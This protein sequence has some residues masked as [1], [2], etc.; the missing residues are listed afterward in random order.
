MRC[1]RPAL[2]LV[3]LSL[4]SNFP[5][6]LAKDEPLVVMWPSTGKPI[7]RFT[8]GKFKSL[9][10]VGSQR[11]YSIET[12]AENLTSQLIPSG[13]FKVYFFDKNQVRIGDTLIAVDNVHPAETVRFQ[14]TAV[15]SGP[16]ASISLTA[17]NEAPKTV[18]L[19]VNS[20]PQGAN[21]VVDGK[22]VGSTPKAVTVGVGKHLL[23]FYKEGFRTGSF[24]LD[25]GAND[26]SGGSVT[27]ELGASALDTI[28]LRDGTVITG[29]LLTVTETEVIIRAGGA[30]QHIDRVKVKRILLTERTP[31]DAP[32]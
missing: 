7:L 17:I 15:T 26:T 16:L 5:I 28:E 3:C 24:P 14:I 12:S 1:V 6:A 2:F 29:D 20:V 25:I 13:S 10:S 30:S 31:L 9:G 8:F 11:T 23:E 4:I 32:R 18:A 21:L 27:Y 19:T 22:P